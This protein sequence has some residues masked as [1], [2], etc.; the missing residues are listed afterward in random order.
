[1]VFRRPDNRR[2]LL[3][4][5]GD[6]TWVLGL[7]V[8]GIITDEGAKPLAQKI[9]EAVGMRKGPGDAQFDYNEIGVLYVQSIIE[10]FIAVDTWYPRHKGAYIHIASCAPFEAK[11]VEDVLEAEGLTVIGRT[12]G[13]L[14]LADL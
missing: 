8:K 9:R 11:T 13:E 2:F 1:V 6:C 3:S 10:S 5:F 4:E 12:W 14:S 7:A